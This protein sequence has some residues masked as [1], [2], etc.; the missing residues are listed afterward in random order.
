MD[1]WWAPLI[2]SMFDPLLGGLYDT[3]PGTGCGVQ[4]CP[5]AFD[6][7]NR[8]EGLGSA[9]Q[10]GYYGYVDK[11]VRM[12]LGRPVEG[13][14]RVLKCADG[15]LAG[16]RAALRRGLSAVVAKLGTDPTKWNAVESADEIVYTAVG[17]VGVDP[18]PWQNRPTFQQV[19]MPTSP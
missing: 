5:L 4:P 16:C 13:R 8:A 10:N 6:D 11:A 14:F 9:F 15:T 12:A 17:L 1:A 19:V 18:Q 3:V 2:H 7:V